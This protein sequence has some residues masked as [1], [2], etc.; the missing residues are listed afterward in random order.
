MY[1]GLIYKATNLINGKCYIGQTISK[2]P[3]KYWFRHL[4]TA[5]KENDNRP[6]YRAIRKYGCENFIWETIEFCNSKKELDE[7][8]FHYIKQYN[9]FINF[10]NS[11]GY[12]ATLGGDGVVGQ[13]PWNKGL[14]NCYSNETL[15]KMSNSRKYIIITEK[16][17]KK[18]SDA[19][20]GKSTWNKG[21]NGCFS[22]EALKKISEANKGKKR[23]PETIQKIQNTKKE[24]TYISKNKGK[25]MFYNPV[26]LEREYFYINNAPDG[27]II[28]KNVKRDEFEKY[29]ES[30]SKYEYTVITP[31][32][33]T[34]IFKS[35]KTFIRENP[36]H[37]ILR[38]MY[39][40]KLQKLNGYTLIITKIKDKICH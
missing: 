16:T 12:N 14:K 29:L 35:L 9:S 37:L 27:W 15:D 3:I 24:R 21:L 2:D 40:N 22:D 25:K 13:F 5:F 20:K 18:M 32:N 28:G 34:I 38:K 11:K 19:R 26:T 7:M 30:R 1:Y 10:K 8:E 17:R 4:K 36:E 33:E 31:N 23:S 6:I 39:R